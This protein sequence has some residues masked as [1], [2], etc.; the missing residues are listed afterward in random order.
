MADQDLQVLLTPPRIKGRGAIPSPVDN[1]QY[2]DED[3]LIK[4]IL[5]DRKIP[6]KLP[7]KVDLTRDFSPVWNQG[8]IG[9]CTAQAGVALME[10]IQRR[11]LKKLGKEDSFIAGSRLFVYKNTR[12]LYGEIGDTGAPITLMMKSLALFG[13]APE[14]FWPYTDSPMAFDRDPPGFCYQ[15]AQSFQALTYFRLDKFQDT[16]KDLVE[17]RKKLLPKIKF[18]I[19]QG[20]PPVFFFVCYK[21]TFEDDHKVKGMIQPPLPKNPKTGKSPT[22]LD[23][24]HA[25]VAAGYDDNYEYTDLKGKKHKGALLIR[26]SWGPEWGVKKGYGYLPYSYVLD[27]LAQEFWCLCKNEWTDTQDLDDSV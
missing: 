20:F 9:S 2:T 25:I 8:N 14:Q 4:A 3:D 6:Q 16:K 5:G 17:N 7:A 23:G 22:G 18:W 10:F 21:G 12:N 27:G 1:R 15:L 19:S 26:N 24:A 13:M 11:Q